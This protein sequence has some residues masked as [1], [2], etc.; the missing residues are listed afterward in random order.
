MSYLYLPCPGSTSLLDSVQMQEACSNLRTFAYAAPA[1]FLRC[2]LPILS[3]PR[4]PATLLLSYL[5]HHLLCVLLIS[6][7]CHSCWPLNSS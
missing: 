7:L 3:G 6:V 2:A 1:L 4:C 5:A